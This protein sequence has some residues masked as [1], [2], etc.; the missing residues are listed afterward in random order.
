MVS[1]RDDICQSYHNYTLEFR[2][3][4]IKI[5][6]I[7]EDLLGCFAAPRTLQGGATPLTL[8]IYYK[9]LRLHIISNYTKCMMILKS[10]TNKIPLA[11]T[12]FSGHVWG[13]LFQALAVTS[14]ITKGVV[15][16]V[17]CDTCYQ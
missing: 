15:A 3:S 11:T 6:Q 5:I 14:V 4:I 16:I 8:V 13:L 7:F 1:K 9:P 17:M 12:R 2:F 10:Q